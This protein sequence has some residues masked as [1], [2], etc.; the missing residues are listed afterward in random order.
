LSPTNKTQ[1]LIS[2]VNYSGASLGYETFG[3]PNKTTKLSS[4][5]NKN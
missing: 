1:V 2:F 4:D 3:D 5:E